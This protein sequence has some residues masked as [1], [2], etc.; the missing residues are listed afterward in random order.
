MSADYPPLTK[1]ARTLVVSHADAP[2]IGN[3]CMQFA[4]NSLTTLSVKR[5]APHAFHD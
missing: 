4:T 1:L 5:I 2:A 3:V